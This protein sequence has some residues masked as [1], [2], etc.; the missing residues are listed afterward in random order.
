MT[1]Q[2]LPES[3]LHS[4]FQKCEFHD[5]ARS[6]CVNRQWHSVTSHDSLWKELCIKQFDLS[7]PFDHHGHPCSS[8]QEA[9]KKWYLSFYKYPSA[10]VVR[11]KKCWEFLRSWTSTNFPEVA[12][13][14]KPGASEEDL[15]DVER[16]LGWSL[17]LPAR[18]LYRFCG[19]QNTFQNSADDDEDDSV[20]KH[21]AG[22]LGGYLFYHHT[23]SVHL[24]SLER[25]LQL[26]QHFIPRWGLPG[27]SRK[28]I[29]IAASYL[30]HKFFLLDCNDGSVH[31]GTKKLVVYGEMMNCVPPSS[32]AAT[33]QDAM[34]CWLE[35]YCT[36]LK[37]G[38]FC[39]RK[40]DGLCSISLFP[41]EEP[42]CTEAV[43]C[44]VQVRCS[45]VFVPELSKLQDDDDDDDRCFFFSYL[46]RMCLLPSGIGSYHHSFNSCQLSKRHWF[47]RENEIP[48]LPVHGHGVI[49]LYPLL[50]SG[51]ET[52]SYASCSPLNTT[53]GSIEG[54]FT[55]VPGSL[56]RQE[57][58]EFH[59]NAARFDLE[60]PK[61][62]F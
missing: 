29:I 49:G 56:T 3:V 21:Y 16:A 8:Y 39:A 30:S 17:P 13:S 24:L 11:A 53:K 25:V 2:A 54:G 15:D 62:I 22:L 36:Q 7:V 23:V 57:G 44:G 6:A 59:V 35:E 9:Y 31:V 18:L 52:F 50:Q 43:T 37:T 20:Y 38:M 47:I 55:F 19:G 46:V 45:A 34:L 14:L 48:L 58:A 28:R 5:V 33:M 42:L 41:E 12:E 4:I 27:T 32:E 61:F 40:T 1:E 10:L 51:G 60:V 26:T